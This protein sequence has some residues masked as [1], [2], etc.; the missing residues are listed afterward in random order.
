M[1]PLFGDSATA[2]AFMRSKYENGCVYVEFAAD[3]GV[4]LIVYYISTITWNATNRIYN[5]GITELT[6]CKRPELHQLGNDTLHFDLDTKTALA[7]AEFIVTYFEEPQHIVKLVKDKARYTEFEAAF[8]QR[9]DKY[10]HV[11]RGIGRS[12][13]FP[14]ASTRC[15]GKVRPD[16]TVDGLSS[17]TNGA[18]SYTE[19]CTVIILAPCPENPTEYCIVGVIVKSYEDPGGGSNAEATIAQR[20]GKS[21]A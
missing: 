16:M 3:T 6:F 14:V 20:L 21:S 9:G 19:P 10:L 7:R 15:S 2:A 11:S 12:S 8:H 1:Q 5:G 17:G 18:E 13:P 4:L